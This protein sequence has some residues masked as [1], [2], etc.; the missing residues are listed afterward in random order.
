LLTGGNF[1]SSI[2]DALALADA[3]NLADPDVAVDDLP[4]GCLTSAATVIG[5][6]ASEEQTN[7]VNTKALEIGAID[8][9]RGIAEIAIDRTT[10]FNRARVGAKLQEKAGRSAKRPRDGWTCVCRYP[11]CFQ[12]AQNQSIAPPYLF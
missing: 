10:D 4:A 5:N 8:I 12:I 2:E 3:A 7:V 6:K 9:E 11:P 1:R